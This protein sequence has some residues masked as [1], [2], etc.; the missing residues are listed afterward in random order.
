VADVAG[1]SRDTVSMGIW[2]LQSGTA[3]P[4]VRVWPLAAPQAVPG[5]QKPPLLEQRHHPL[6]W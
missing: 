6:E 3:Q 5:K 4:S 2:E 1:V